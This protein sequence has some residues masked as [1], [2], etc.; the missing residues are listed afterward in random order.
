M[1]LKPIDFSELVINPQ[2]LIDRQALVLTSGDFATHVFNA[3]TISW[4]LIGV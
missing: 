1:D 4:G 2:D 3:M